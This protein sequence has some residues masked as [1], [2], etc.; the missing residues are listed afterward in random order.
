MTI[1]DPQTCRLCGG[2]FTV[3]ALL[4]SATEYWP[5][6]NVVFAE[7]PCCQTREEL[8]IETN[9]VWR[10]YSYAAGVPHYCAMEE[11]A[12]PGLSLNRHGSTVTYVFEGQ[13]RTLRLIS[14]AK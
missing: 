1:D 7:S 11:Y 6:L 8:Q 10:G 4:H 13:E 9:K 12:V 2:T 14:A 3:R 5:E